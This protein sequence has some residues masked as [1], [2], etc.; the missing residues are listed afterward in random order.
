MIPEAEIKKVIVE[1]ENISD[2]EKEG[3]TNLSVY[4]TKIELEQIKKLAELFGYPTLNKF[5][6]ARILPSSDTV[7][8]AL[9]MVKSRG[10]K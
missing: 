9:E 10:E 6:R 1:G 8:K 3:K 5:I 2:Y 7:I 4:L